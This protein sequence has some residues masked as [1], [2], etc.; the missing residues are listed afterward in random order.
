L[1]SKDVTLTAQVKSPDGQT[2]EKK[3]VVTIQRVE[4]TQDG[5]RRNGRPIITRIQGL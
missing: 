4:G 2:A 1:V 5:N 3:L